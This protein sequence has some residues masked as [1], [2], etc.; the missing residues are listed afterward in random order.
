MD[1]KQAGFSALPFGTVNVFCREHKIPLNPI[2]AAE[3]FNP[4]NTKKLALGFLGDRPFLL[5]CGIG[6][7]ASVVRNVTEKK[8][9]G[10]K[11]FWHLY[12]GVKVLGEKY[13]KLTLYVDG[14]E[15]NVYH[16]IVSLGRLY[17]GNFVL[18]KYIK[19]NTLNVFVN[20][21]STM[22]NLLGSILSMVIG[23]GFP[24]QAILTDMVKVSGTQ[25]FQLDGEYVLMPTAQ[26][27]IRIKESAITLVK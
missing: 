27:Y 25:H 19:E 14:K 13:P 24:E 6:Y 15:I 8:Y 1:G 20:K 2:K 23:R 10:H 7:D 11:T 5:M 18:S 3:Q 16:T 17:A 4:N 22:R 12:E 21:S 9:H 26:N